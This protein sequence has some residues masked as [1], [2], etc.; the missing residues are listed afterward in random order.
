MI[1]FV[2]QNQVE[3]TI[4]MIDM[5]MPINVQ[6]KMVIFEEDLVANIW[7]ICE[8]IEWDLAKNLRGLEVICF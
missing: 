4:A 5:I 3:D 8:S 1:E 2:Q 6:D 7:L